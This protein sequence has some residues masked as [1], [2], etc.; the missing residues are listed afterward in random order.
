M[1]TLYYVP[2]IHSVEDYGSLGPAIKKAFERRGGEAAFKHIQ[3]DIHEYWKL[4]EKRIERAIPDVRGLIIY[5]DGFPVGSKEKVLALFGHMCQDHPQSSNF[6]LVKKLLDKGAALEG[7][8]D[9]NLVMEQLKLYQR[10]AETESCEEQE[11]IIAAHAARS[12]EITKLRDEFIAKRIHDT[13]PE[14]GKGI[15]FIGRDHDVASEL[16]KQPRKFI[17]ICL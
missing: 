10:A 12:R 11:K 4:V 6:R 8:E 15:L 1:S 3:K 16:E 9:I 14:T 13:L 7:T 2:M 5:H 17:V